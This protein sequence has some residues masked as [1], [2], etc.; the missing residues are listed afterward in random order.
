MISLCK[1]GETR[2]DGRCKN[3]TLG[4]KVP[5]GIAASNKHQYAFGMSEPADEGRRVLR[6]SNER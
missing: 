3:I 2:P 4:F 5:R 1:E 6:A